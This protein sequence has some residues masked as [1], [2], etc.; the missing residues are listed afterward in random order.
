M[1][2]IRKPL[3]KKT[4]DTS[5]TRDDPYVQDD[6]EYYSAIINLTNNVLQ[7]TKPMYTNSQILEIS[8]SITKALDDIIDRSP[9]SI[10]SLE[11]L[12]EAKFY[13]NQAKCLIKEMNAEQNK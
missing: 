6:I 3:E 12:H 2:I 1:Q 7:N 11:I 5:L 10:L 4:I 8:D 9:S 13:N